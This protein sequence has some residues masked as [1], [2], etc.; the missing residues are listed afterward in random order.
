[1]ARYR[2][3]SKYGNTFVIKLFHADM[4]DLHIEEGD[5]VDLD[6]IVIV[7]KSQ[8]H[9]NNNALS[10]S[11]KTTRNRLKVKSPHKKKVAKLKRGNQ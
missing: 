2:Q 6:D 10:R 5:I 11:A 9:G 4:K 1:M 7:N 3:I 8:A